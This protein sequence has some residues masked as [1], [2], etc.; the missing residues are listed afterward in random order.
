M[1]LSSKINLRMD[2]P[3]NFSEF[4]LTGKQK[5][6]EYLHLGK[7]N[8]VSERHTKVLY[9]LQYSDILPWK[10]FQTTFISMFISNTPLRKF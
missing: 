3:E 7:E 6:N 2:A 4:E 9:Y 1:S 10:P 5:K 8:L